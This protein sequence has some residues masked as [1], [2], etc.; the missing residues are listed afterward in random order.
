[1]PAATFSFWT[2]ANPYCTK[3]KVARVIDL[4][5]VFFPAVLVPNVFRGEDD[6]L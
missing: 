3:L 2:R 4:L 1:M 5:C 6:S